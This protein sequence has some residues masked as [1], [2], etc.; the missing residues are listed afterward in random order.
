VT[1]AVDLT[2]ARLGAVADPKFRQARMVRLVEIQASL[3]ANRDPMKPAVISR[4]FSEIR[5]PIG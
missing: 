1:K 3:A 4:S 5:G 2:Q